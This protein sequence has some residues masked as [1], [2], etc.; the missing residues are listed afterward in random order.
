MGST[1]ISTK[2]LFRN[3][4]LK[5]SICK[6][7]SNPPLVH[8]NRRTFYPPDLPYFDP[9]KEVPSTLAHDL[10]KKLFCYDS[11]YSLIIWLD[12]IAAKYEISD[13]ECK[14]SLYL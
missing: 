8:E 10:R 6:V 3:P 13:C 5:L 2:N 4:A 1:L 14:N 9:H 11:T 12:D 7:E